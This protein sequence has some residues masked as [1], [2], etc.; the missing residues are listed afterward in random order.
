MSHKE[1]ERT[2]DRGMNRKLTEE[3]ERRD[4]RE[5]GERG[6]GEREKRENSNSKRNQ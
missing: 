1:R 3:R 4:D 5:R 6:K 2:D